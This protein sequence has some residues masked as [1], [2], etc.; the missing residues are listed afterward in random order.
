MSD[1][2][3]EYLDKTW[4][5]VVGCTPIA[6]GCQN[7][8]ARGL[9]NMRH[10]AFL[11]GKKMPAQY[12]KPFSEVQLMPH[13]L[14]EPLHWRKPAW[15]GVAFGGD[16]YHESV[17]SEF[18]AAVHA[19]ADACPQHTFVSLTKRGDRMAEFYRWMTTTARSVIRGLAGWPKEEGLLSFKLAQEFLLGAGHPMIMGE[20]EWPVLNWIQGV[21]VS[22][23]ADADK[24]LPHLLACP[25]ARRMVSHEPALGP[26]DWKGMAGIDWLVDGG[27]TGKGS[28][29]AHPDWFRSNQRQCAAAG[30][31]YWHKSNGDW[32]E[33]IK[34]EEYDTS[35]GR[36]QR[37]PAF[38]VGRD[39][40]VRCYQNDC[41]RNG[42]TMVHVG[43]RVAGAL[44]D[45]QEYR[46]LP[47]KVAR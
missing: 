8:W 32:R 47:G 16:L 37:H 22:T 42:I 35:R 36:A 21:S 9:H 28:R 39:G 29:P 46:Q 6:A 44:I 20:G 34:G 15:W 43:K 24:Q 12:A 25:A 40:L 1:T 4:G 31:A 23:Q 18:I 41:N 7:C 38:I 45:G 27:E 3:I 5:V 17:P 2:G 11:A 26:I 13:R 14:A 30:V 19:V 10:A 33:P